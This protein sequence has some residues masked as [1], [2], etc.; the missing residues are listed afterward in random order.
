[1]KRPQQP[2]EA[3]FSPY[4]T[5]LVQ[6]ADA[7][8]DRWLSTPDKVPGGADGARFVR[9]ALL[10]VLRG[11]VP[12][13]SLRCCR[14][15]AARL[16]FP[17]VRL[18]AE[19]QAGVELLRRWARGDC[20]ETNQF[21]FVVF[22]NGF[23]NWSARRLPAGRTQREQ[24]EWIS[25]GL[26]EMPQM[27]ARTQGH[28]WHEPWLCWAEVLVRW[29]G[30]L[31]FLPQR[32]RGADADRPQGEVLEADPELHAAPGEADGAGADESGTVPP[33]LRSELK[34]QI[35]QLLAQAGPGEH[36]ALAA[37]VSPE[38]QERIKRLLASPEIADLIASVRSGESGTVPRD[39]PPELKAEF[40][41]L[42]PLVGGGTPEPTQGGGKVDAARAEI[43]L[44]DWVR[45]VGDALS[46][47]PGQRR[48]V[49]WVRA[50]REVVAEALEGGPQ[51]RLGMA[52]WPVLGVAKTVDDLLQQKL[53]RDEVR[54]RCRPETANRNT[55][56]TWMMFGL[57]WLAAHGLRRIGGTGDAPPEGMKGEQP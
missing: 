6:R 47:E 49:K 36:K 22:S 23:V 56:A 38:V 11:E 26:T 34:N 41:D 32:I 15:R 17:V 50:L 14:L 1:M 4:L 44:R 52:L 54:E 9:L 39:L 43:E 35:K 55:Y 29:F 31:K 48:A 5:G 30:E 37:Q 19:V 25:G 28:L 20:D 10:P 3:E 18:D 27:F 46:A 33:E 42:I 12:L 24:K 7:E 40:Q 2:K 53:I 51:S 21:V 16:A 8:L 57:R 45:R 13:D